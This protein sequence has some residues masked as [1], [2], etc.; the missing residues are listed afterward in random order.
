MKRPALT[1][2]CTLMIFFVSAQEFK[3]LPA[4]GDVTK[5]ELQLTE[6]SFDKGAAAMVIFNEGES[7]YRLNLNSQ[8]LPYFAQTDFRV[9][10]KIFNQKGFDFA[11]IK[12][13][14]PSEDR[15][16]NIVKLSAQTYNLDAAGNIVA[17]K[18]DKASI[19]DKRINK[20]YS[21]KSFAF[22]DIKPGSIIEYK[23]TL[24]NETESLW[25]F[26]K[27]IPV[28]FSRFI[29]NFPPELI[30]TIT[31][32]C[33]LPLQRASSDRKG[34]GNY[35]WYTMENVPG[36]SDEPF[37]SCRED[38][39]Q[40][41]E[42]RLTAID[43]PGIPRIDRRRTWPGVIRNLLE[44]DY[45]GRQLKKELPRTADLDAMLKNENDP[46]KKMVII[47]NY[48]RSNMEWNG[49]SD[50]GAMDG[51]KSAWKDK[52][53]TSGEINLILINLLKDAGLNVY[54]VLVSTKNN[55]LVNTSVA[56]YDQFDKVMAHVTIG[57]NYYVLDAT[58]KATPSDLIPIDVMATEAL[59]IAKPDSYEWGW[60]TLWNTKNIYSRSI[61]LNAE[62]DTS[63]NLKGAAKLVANG[64]ERCRLL[65]EGKNSIAKLKNS[66]DDLKG[67][68]VDSISTENAEVDSLPLTENIYFQS[69]GSS[70]G[71]Y[72]YFSVNLFTG[73]EKNPFLAEERA[74]DILYSANQ[75]YEINGLVFIPEGYTMEELPKSVRMIMPDTSISFTRQSVYSAGILNI[76]YQLEFRKPFFSKEEYPEFR[77]FYKKLFS[78][79]NEQFVYRKEK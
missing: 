54:P 47:H 50:I 38:Y 17:T 33:S 25:Y 77:E 61:T 19:F 73:L 39:L 2:L 43:F 66:F 34:A 79:L 55:G 64:Y 68:R 40:K 44:N 59:L 11:N 20:Q 71:G 41:L 53:G 46:H 70:T 69:T 3:K 45:F 60:K 52:K 22:P 10:I 9:R 72:K 42:M 13:R 58:E 5:E 7:F 24:D 29:V 21:E 63:G 15:S 31:P 4:F 1:L 37:M 32:H 76:R 12:I 65:P 57:D 35:S 75:K 36:L 74:T 56:G 26:Q 16:V 78:L 28:Q 30:M 6:C 48:V 62:A 49:Y 23:Y 18:V 27:K 67:I 8:N 14:Y 51:V